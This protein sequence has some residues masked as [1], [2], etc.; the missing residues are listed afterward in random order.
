ML[1]A[2]TLIEL[3]NLLGLDVTMQVTRL[4]AVICSKPVEGRHIKE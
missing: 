1:N 3:N 4:D 2:N